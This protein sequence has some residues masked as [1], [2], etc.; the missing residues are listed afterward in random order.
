MESWFWT[1]CVGHYRAEEQNCKEK[2]SDL[3]HLHGLYYIICLEIQGDK[4]ERMVVAKK[5]LKQGIYRAMR[6]SK[7]RCEL[8]KVSK[9]LFII[10]DNQ[11]PT[12]HQ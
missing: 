12:T 7:W 9:V 11:R 1:S 6:R 8:P 5:E 2:G 4:M 10:T 3:G